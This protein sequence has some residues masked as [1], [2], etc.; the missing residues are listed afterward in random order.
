MPLSSVVVSTIQSTSE[1]ESRACACWSSRTNKF[2]PWR[3]VPKPT[4]ESE[5]TQKQKSM[6]WAMDNGY[7]VYTSHHPLSFCQGLMSG[8]GAFD[9][10]KYSVVWLYQVRKRRTSSQLWIPYPGN[11]GQ[12]YVSPFKH[13]TMLRRV[14]AF[15]HSAHRSFIVQGCM[16]M[17]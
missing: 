8:G 2:S 11:K 9:H 16:G 7:R 6:P 13:R 14:R 3:S 10:S 17:G 15:S 5:K 4:A 12:R 1:T